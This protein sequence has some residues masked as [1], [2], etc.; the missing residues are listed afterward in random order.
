MKVLALVLDLILIVFWAFVVAYVVR[1]EQI[2]CE[3][4]KDWKRDFIK[5]YLLVIIPIMILKL[6][7]DLPVALAGLTFVFG[8]TF[9]FVV[10]TYIQ[11]LRKKKCEC[12]KAPIR[13]ILEI[14]NYIQIFLIGFALVLMLMIAIASLIRKP[15]VVVIAPPV[16]KSKK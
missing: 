12:S 16:K 14:F 9:I 3:C 8:L 11:E 6:F 10:F 5:Y 13:D 4:S 2:G 1:L 7:V 15:T